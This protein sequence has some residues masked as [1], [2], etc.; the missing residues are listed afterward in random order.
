[1]AISARPNIGAGTTSRT[2]TTL[3]GLADRI[4]EV[5]PAVRAQLEQFVRVPSVSSDPAHAVDV[6]RS[7]ELIGS[8]YEAIG[9]EVTLAAAG[10]HD[11]VIARFPSPGDAVKVLLYAHH[12]VQPAGDVE[13]WNSPVFEANERDGRLF[14]RG[15]ADD[16]AG[17]A[18]HLAAVAAV[19]AHHGGL[20]VD[21]TVLIDGEEEIG[22]PTLAAIVDR[23]LAGADPDVVVIAD[24]VNWATGVPSLTTSMRGMVDLVVEVRT[25]EHALHSGAWGG[26]APDALGALVRTLA[27]L[28]REDGGV[29]VD[30][31]V[32]L[33][34]PAAVD[35]DEA[36]FRADAGVLD[37][38]GL[39]GSGT[40]TDRLW[41]QP[42]ATI[43]GI[44]APRVDE[45][46]PMLV[47]SARAKVSLRIPLRNDPARAMAALTRHLQAHAPHGAHVIVT[48]GA[49]AYP[50]EVGVSPVLR[51]TVLDALRHGW[52]GVEPV[53][54]GCGG[55]LPLIKLF[56]DRFPRTQILVTGVE[57][58][59]TRAHAPNESLHLAD[60]RSACLAEAALL[61][62]LA[63]EPVV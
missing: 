36:T 38:V 31:L 52:P 28:Y 6:R 9:A 17:V 60:F 13:A 23:H 26:A 41:H 22:S 15:A 42:S 10:G 30:G 11:S 7:A 14:G 37:G 16:K 4:D 46:A 5:L 12:D 51:Q 20:P 39:P 18:V 21:L 62:L 59:D 54:M 19:T 63:A 24:A 27:S 47:A 45:A 2:E 40:I 49:S 61:Q 29:A 57:D 53:E 35:Y 3:L 32:S 34:R 33:S 48:P 55:T 8:A 25:L 56:Q 43:T 50:A 1:M 44:D 58:P